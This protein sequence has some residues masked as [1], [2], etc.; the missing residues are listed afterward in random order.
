MSKHARLYKTA[1]WLARR[2]AQL[3]AEPVCRLCLEIEGR[4]TT[5]TVA[6]HVRP[7]RGDQMLFEGELQSLCKR[8]HDSWKKQ[9]EE[10]GYFDGFDAKGDPLDPSHPWYRTEPSQP[11]G[12]RGRAEPAARTVAPPPKG[13]LSIFDSGE[14][15][16]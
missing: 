13:R 7:H 16:A 1:R 12:T 11:G 3:R 10:R 2:E 14:N 4:I 6:D 8:H 5:A 9:I 15:D